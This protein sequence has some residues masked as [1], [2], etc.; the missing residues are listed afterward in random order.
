MVVFLPNL[1][2]GASPT[3]TAAGGGPHLLM[4]MN[5]GRMWWLPVVSFVKEWLH[6]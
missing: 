1:A 2:M 4:L 6:G 3:V 5:V